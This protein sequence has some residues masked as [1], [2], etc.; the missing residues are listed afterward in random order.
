MKTRS[1]FALAV[2]ALCSWACAQDPQG[3][4]HLEPREIDE[5]VGHAAARTPNPQ[6]R[7]KRAG[8][9]PTQSVE[10]IHAGQRPAEPRNSQAGEQREQRNP[11][12]LIGVR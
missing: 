7:A 10:N 4:A 6:P 3:R 12:Q 1:A 9:K 11:Q 2:C 8:R 5:C